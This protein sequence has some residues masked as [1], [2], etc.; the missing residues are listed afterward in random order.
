MTP[1]QSTLY[2]KFHII[3]I[4]LRTIDRLINQHEINKAREIIERLMKESDSGMKHILDIWG[5]E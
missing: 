3:S 1:D 4:G 5:M 2:N